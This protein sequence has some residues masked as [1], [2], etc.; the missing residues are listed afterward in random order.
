MNPFE[1]A[2]LWAAAA[3]FA[4]WLYL[5]ARRPVRRRVST[6]RFWTSIPGI[7]QPRRRRIREP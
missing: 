1:F 3:A 6:L 4:V 2:G 5:H 7:S